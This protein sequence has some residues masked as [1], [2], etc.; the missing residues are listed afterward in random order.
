MPLLTVADR[1]QGPVALCYERTRR[2]GFTLLEL[3]VVLL[4][5]AL[6]SAALVIRVGAP[7]RKVQLDHTLARLEDLDRL[8]RATARRT[9][10][11]VQLEVDPAAGTFTSQALGGDRRRTGRVV[12]L[13]AGLRIDRSASAGRQAG[14]GPLR[15]AIA[16]AGQSE[17]YALRLAT[18]RGPAAWLIVVGA[19]GQYVRT[20]EESVVE[21]AL[22]R[23]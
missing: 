17:S 18:P 2:R 20:Q 21:K 15:L 10:R 8:A 23:R 11:P 9:G 6:A 7:F 1:N 5:V 12:S 4:I 14:G 16:P 13:P 22:A 3:S 19:S